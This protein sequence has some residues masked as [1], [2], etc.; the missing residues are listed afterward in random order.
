M[1]IDLKNIMTI[2]LK[3]TME[4]DLQN[5]SKQYY[6]I[7]LFCPSWFQYRD[8]LGLFRSLSLAEE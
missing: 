6:K 1:I 7:N 3:N 2:D 5:I 4:I 8:F